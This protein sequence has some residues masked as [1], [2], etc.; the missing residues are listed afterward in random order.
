MGTKEGQFIS[1]RGV[2]IT[3]DGHIMV[4]DCHRLQKL[5]VDGV[6]VKSVGSRES[7]RGQLQFHFPTGIAV[8]PN[9]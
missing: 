4:T 5:T 8:H 7:G 1:P 9:T 6:R 2:A 3:T